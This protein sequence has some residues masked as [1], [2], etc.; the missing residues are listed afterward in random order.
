MLALEAKPLPDFPD[1]PLK[2]EGW[3]KYKA[4]NLYERL[5]LDRKDSPAIR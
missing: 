1:D 5:C 2:W 3:S 4:E